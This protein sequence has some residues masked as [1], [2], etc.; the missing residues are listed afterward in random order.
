L[1]K[2]TPLSHTHTLTAIRARLLDHSHLAEEDPREQEDEGER[3]TKGRRTEEGEERIGSG[4]GT[5]KERRNACV[6]KRTRRTGG[7]RKKEEEQETR[8]LSAPA[9]RVAAWAM[10]H[11]KACQRYYLHVYI[12]SSSIVF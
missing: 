1:L 3:E 6:K 2:S 8:S 10:H 9:V 12:S 5:R 11:P 7:R 4:D